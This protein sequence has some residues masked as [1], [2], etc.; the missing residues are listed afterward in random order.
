M[1]IISS[2]CKSKGYSPS[3][4]FVIGASSGAFFVFLIL[5]SGFIT[6][7]ELM[8]INGNFWL[9]SV[10]WLTLTVLAGVRCVDMLGKTSGPNA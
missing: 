8:L 7:G 3:K 1:G 5:A 2:Q 6:N 9:T 4:S 10:A